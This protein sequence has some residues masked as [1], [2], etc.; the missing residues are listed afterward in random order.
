MASIIHPSA[1]RRSLTH[2]LLAG[3]NPLSPPAASPSLHRQ[4][5]SNPSL[6]PLPFNSWIG[7]IGRAADV[8]AGWSILPHSLSSGLAHSLIGYQ[9]EGVDRVF[10][11]GRNEMG[12]LGVGW[13]S[14]EGTRGLVEAF[15]GDG[16][17]GV[18]AGSQSSYM[19]VKEGGAIS[20]QS[21][22]LYAT[23]IRGGKDSTA[24]WAFGSL[25]RGRL[26]HPGAAAPSEIREQDE[27]E[28][29][30]LA[31]A[32]RLDLPQ[33]VGSIQDAQVGFEHLL[34]LSE[35]GEIYGTGC[36]TDGQLGLGEEVVKDVYEITRMPLPD[37]VVHEGVARIR[38][39]AD[40]S[41]LITYSGDLYT[42]GNSEYAQG[43][44]GHKID[45]I[46]SPTLVPT[47]SFLQPGRKII[48]I[49]CGGSFS[50]L[51]DDHGSV[52]SA[53]FG[54]LGL[55]SEVLE[56]HA[57]QRIPSLEGISR[58]RAGWGWA[59]A[60][61]DKGPASTIYTWGVNNAAGRLGV[62][63]TR[64]GGPAMH[65]FEPVQLELPLRELDM[66]AEDGESR[67]W[68]L[69]EVECG[70]DA[71]WATMVEDVTDTERGYDD[72]EC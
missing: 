55:G 28:L 33:G 16:V 3:N 24:V 69:G 51:L 2:L 19:L 60:V 36:N 46:H 41:A 22:K 39:G 17:L 29:K 57:V 59:V 40:T 34:L 52:Y 68:E 63:R 14:H 4:S 25:Q 37:Q 15:E 71:L 38:A 47:K 5:P 66:H 32:T 49:R 53:G 26:G 43:L 58:I 20:H 45:Q 64:K 12:Q 44:H 50:L 30:M 6:T 8:R 27:P 70:Q 1:A 67:I 7:S 21:S 54:A 65:V 62:G 56:S 23:L 61:R 35:G 72:M 10:A 11:V 42:W 18:R 48:D 13:N 9:S 31:K